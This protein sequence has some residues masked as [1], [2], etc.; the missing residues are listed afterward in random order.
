MDQITRRVR[1]CKL[2]ERMN[3]D[4]EYAKKLGLNDV[5]EF[6]ESKMKGED[7]NERFFK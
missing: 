1:M 4:I 5:S 7:E 6:K 2:I 3:R